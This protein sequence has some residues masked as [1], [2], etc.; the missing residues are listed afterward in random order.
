MAKKVGITKLNASTID[1]L[2]TIR[3]NASAAYQDNVPVV[4]KANVI[5]QVGDVLYGY[6]ALANEF[7]NAL[8]SRIAAVRI[9][10]AEFNSEYADLK[11]GYLDFGETVEEAFVQITKAKVYDPEKGVERELKRYL[12]DVRAAFHAVNWKVM[13]PVTV[14]Q[15]ELTQ[16]FLSVEGVT[17]LIARIIN[18]VTTAAEYDEYLLF[19]YLIIKAVSHGEMYPVPFD[20]ANMS[21]AAKMFR[22]YS[23][24]LT[25]MKREYNTSNVLNVT[26]RNNQYIFM[27]AQ[28]NADYDVDVL[29][30][31]FNMDKA[32]FMGHL[33]LVD[34]WTTFDNE[35]FSEI[36]E[37]SDMIETVTDDELALMANVKAILIDAEWF[38]VYDK[39]QVMRDTPVNSSLYWNYFYHVWKIVS[40][41]PF[42]NA[43]VFVDDG[44]TTTLPETMTLHI[45]SIEES[46]NATILTFTVYNDDEAPAIYQQSANFIQTDAM[47]ADGIAMHKYGA[48]IVPTAKVG[49]AITISV[50][51]GD[52]QYNSTTAVTPNVAEVDS[53]LSLQRADA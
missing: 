8:V 50:Q 21:N 26:P 16:A 42:S 6:P 29:A 49:T 12:P 47:S 10:S 27:D 45:D 41:S 2:N 20:S 9:K 15:E 5:P 33:K 7:V 3:Q 1:I 48:M 36:M 19:K 38:Q 11:K 24:K 39:L 46:D 40:Y 25:F 28:F 34:D 14:S 4:D 30:A 43:I 53:T 18:N 37:E 31:A 13:Y 22:G 52:K 17:D 35:R 51:I 32:D 23:N 44:A